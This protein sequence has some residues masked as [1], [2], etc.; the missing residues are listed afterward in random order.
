MSKMYVSS[1]ALLQRRAP[2]TLGAQRAAFSTRTS[3]WQQNVETPIQTQ[4]K[5]DIVHPLVQPAEGRTVQTPLQSQTPSE[6]ASGPPPLTIRDPKPLAVLFGGLALG[7]VF[8]YYYYERRKA[9]M[10]QK[11]E[12]MLQEA[13]SNVVGGG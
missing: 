3:R 6:M 2:A 4:K 8:V 7:G 9:H 1:R 12:K 10:Q 11:W 13:K 5:E